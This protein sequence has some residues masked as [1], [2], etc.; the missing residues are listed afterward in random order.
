MNNMPPVKVADGARYTRVAVLLH[1]LIALFFLFNVSLGFF[2]EGFPRP[3]KSV[4]LGLHISSGFTVLCLSVL[5]LLWRLSHRPPAMLPAPGWQKGAAHGVHALLYVLMFAMPLT[6]IAILSCHP[7]A[8]G[9]GPGAPKVWGLFDLPAFSSL[10]DLVAS[11]QKQTHDYYVQLHSVLGWVALTL[12]VL[13][14]GAALK[15]QFRDKE[16]ELE[17]MRW[18]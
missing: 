17:R 6:W 4:V 1:W 14:V 16:P 7:R 18:H 10:Q 13:H 15:H 2:M 11:V 9:P 5:R 3:V 8:H 12:L